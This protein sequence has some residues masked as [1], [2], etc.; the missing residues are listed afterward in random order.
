MFGETDRQTK[1]H[2][3]THTHKHRDKKT[4]RGHCVLFWGH[5]YP[6][7]HPKKGPQLHP[8]TPPH[9]QKKGPQ[10]P[11]SPITEKLIFNSKLTPLNVKKSLTKQRRKRQITLLDDLPG[12]G[13]IKKYKIQGGKT[14]KFLSYV[15]MTAFFKI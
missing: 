12:G 15:I 9:T 8:R 4:G 1:T 13:G 5:R 7:P 10:W 11:T 3:N 6:I 2:T 14:P